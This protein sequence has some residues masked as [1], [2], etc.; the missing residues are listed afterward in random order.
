MDAI[1]SLWERRHQRRPRKGEKFERNTCHLSW[2]EKIDLPFI[3]LTS[4]KLKIFVCQTITV[5]CEAEANWKSRT[6]SRDNREVERSLTFPRKKEEKKKRK[7]RGF[8]RW[9]CWMDHEVFLARSSRPENSAAWKNGG[10]EGVRGDG[11][12]LST[13]RMERSVARSHA[14]SNLWCKR[15][16]WVSLVARHTLV[17]AREFLDKS[18]STMGHQGIRLVRWRGT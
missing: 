11:W 13:G 18:T 10:K 2:G 14:T 7:K 8:D 9:L 1:V 15:F 12:W 17:V 3:N 5:S 4:N 16:W 6:K